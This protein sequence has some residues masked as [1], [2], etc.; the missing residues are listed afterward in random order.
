MQSLGKIV[1]R[2]PAVGAKIWCLSLLIDF[3][4]FR[5]C[6]AAS[7]NIEVRRS[8]LDRHNPRIPH[9]DVLPCGLMLFA[10]GGTGTYF[11]LQLEPGT[12]LW[13]VHKI[14]KI[15]VEILQSVNNGT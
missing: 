15:A 1:Q 2:A 4:M 14:R 10:F 3:M 9:A 6:Q 8:T 13:K 12:L 5:L 7:R 11:L